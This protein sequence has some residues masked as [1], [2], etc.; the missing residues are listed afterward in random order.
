M[1]ICERFPNVTPFSIRREQI[2]EVFLLIRRLKTYN[3]KENN[4]KHYET[5]NGKTRCYVPVM[6]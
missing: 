4:K 5:V 3:A 6:N 2:S 1:E